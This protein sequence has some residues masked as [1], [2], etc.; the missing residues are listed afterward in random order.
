MMRVLIFCCPWQYEELER[1]LN[2]I[3]ARHK[4]QDQEALSKMQ[5]QHLESRNRVH[6]LGK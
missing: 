1:A 3:H 6:E 4:A 2:E 5:R